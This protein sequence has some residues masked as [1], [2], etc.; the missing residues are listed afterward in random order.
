MRAGM[1]HGG[2]PR[3]FAP[4]GAARKPRPAGLGGGR[5]ERPGGPA[6]RAV[7]TPD[8]TI[9]PPRTVRS[10]IAQGKSQRSP[11]AGHGLPRE[12]RRGRAAHCVTAH[13]A[14]PVRPSRCVAA[15]RPGLPERTIVRGEDPLPGHLCRTR[16]NSAARFSRDC[17]KKHR[18]R[19]TT[20][21]RRVFIAPGAAS[22]R[23][24]TFFA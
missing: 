11:G 5:G 6:G 22:R 9:S 3:I 8:T 24:R 13:G 7:A 12:P 2:L 23:S 17:R 1:L 4:Q 16:T 14:R 18:I 20:A 21:H 10:R 19:R 15:C